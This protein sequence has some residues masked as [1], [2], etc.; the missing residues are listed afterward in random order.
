MGRFVHGTK[1]GPKPLLSKA[2]ETELSN[3][4]LDVAKAGYGK[5]RKQV[6]NLA[7]AV[8]RDKGRLTTTKKL[9]DGWFRRFMARQPHL[10]MRKGDPTANVRMDC[11]TKET[12]DEY[13]QLLKDTLIENDLMDSP[14]QIYNVDE[15]GMP[16]DHRAPKIVA[17]RGHKKVRYRNVWQ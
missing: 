17:G 1:P 3:F 2:E 9:T 16:L 14:N 13:F 4:L 5:S 15:T 8:A 6:K 12:M 7:E 11:L 10:S